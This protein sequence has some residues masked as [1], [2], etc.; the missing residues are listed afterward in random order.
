MADERMDDI[1][2]EARRLGDLIRRHPRYRRLREADARV[3]DDGAATEALDAYNKA[4]VAVQ[5][6]EARG[7]PVEVEDKRN[8]ERLRDAVA[9]NDT[10]KAFSTAQVD[11]AEMM[12]RMNEAIF[13]AIAG[14]DADL[15]DADLEEDEDAFGPDDGPDVVMP[16]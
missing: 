10:V 1:L 15:D 2:E 12:Q 9:S 7:R 16:E 3:R 14:A 4:A 13:R 8:L 11:Y 6:K 5:Q